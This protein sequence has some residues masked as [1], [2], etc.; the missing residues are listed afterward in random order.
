[1][2]EVQCAVCSVQCALSSEHLLVH[3]SLQPIFFFTH[4]YLV[5]LHNLDIKKRL[6]CMVNPKS[7][8]RYNL[9]IV[10][11]STL[12]HQ[13]PW[14]SMYLL[15]TLD[16]Q[17]LIAYLGLLCTHCLPWT[18]MYSLP[19]L[20][21]QVLVIYLGPLCT[22]Y[23]PWTTRYPLPT[24]EPLCTHYLQCTI[25]LDNIVAFSHLLEFGHTL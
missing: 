25:T 8:E 19:T 7:A 22:C 12:D 23:L 17:V 10:S 4:L 6:R 5:D 16:H 3:Y 11:L 14:T 24:L 2:N 18:P 21:H 9:A 1:M 13:V 20:N 15:P